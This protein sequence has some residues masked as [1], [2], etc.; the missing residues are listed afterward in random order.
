MGKYYGA[1]GYGQ[2]QEITPGI[3]KVLYTERIVYGDV[4]N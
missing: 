4:I 1:I 3:W 2:S